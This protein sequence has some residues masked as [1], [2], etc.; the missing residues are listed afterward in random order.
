VLLTF[1]LFYVIF[2]GECNI[3]KYV[4]FTNHVVIP[5]K[6][7]AGWKNPLKK[8]SLMSLK[9]VTDLGG[10]DAAMLKSFLE[11]LFQWIP[12]CFQAGGHLSHVRPIL[13]A[14]ILMHLEEQ[15]KRQGPLDPVVQ[16][17]HGAARERKV[18][19]ARLYQW[20]RLIKA[21]FRAVNAKNQMEGE[22][23][24][25]AISESL[26]ALTMSVQLRDEEIGKL[27]VRLSVC[28]SCSARSH[29][30]RGLTLCFLSSSTEPHQDHAIFV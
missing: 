23:D 22:A 14:S 30:L 28:L 7:L 18:S 10:D 6:A 13:A 11:E 19:K 17:V 12:D 2:A 26:A 8:V 5:G 20:G 15:E 1:V 25:S 27:K 9:P 4:N 3:T 24:V 29:S 16:K 21:E